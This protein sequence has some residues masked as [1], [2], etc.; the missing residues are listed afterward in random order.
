[1]NE[2]PIPIPER[3]RQAKEEI[4]KTVI[5]PGQ[6]WFLTL[7]FLLIILSVPGLQI[8]RD[9]MATGEPIR[10]GQVFEILPEVAASLSKAP[11]VGLFAANRLLLRDIDR[12][13]HALDDASVLKR[14]LLKPAQALLTEYLRTGSE[15]VYTGVNGW[16]FYRQA[17]EHLFGAPFLDPRRMEARRR[18]ANVWERPPQPDPRIALAEF[19]G[20]LSRRGI[21]LVLVAVPGKAAIQPEQFVGRPIPLGDDAAI[22]NP[23]T[24]DVF[25]F[26]AEQGAL[27]FDAAQSL[28]EYVRQA[29]RPAFLKTD[30]H[31]T[32]DAMERVARDL[33]A[34]VK[35]RID[36]PESRGSSGTLQAATCKAHGDL[37]RMLGLPDDQ[38]M[39][40]PESVTI[41]RVRQP[42]GSD[43]TPDSLSP[44]LLL[45]DSFGNIYSDPMLGWGAS[46]GLAEHLSAQL[47]FP[48][49]RICRNDDGA[50]ATRAELASELRLGNDR[51]R[52][53]RL[54]IWEFAE[55]EFSF[56]DWRSIPLTTGS[57][58]DGQ[59]SPVA[60]LTVLA[61]LSGMG[62]CP[63]PGSTPYR[64][65]L[66]WLSLTDF[67]E[68]AGLTPPVLA[69]IRT[70]EDGK[71]TT[72]ATLRTG[73]KYRFLLQ[74]WTDVKGNLGR[75][76]REDP[77]ADELVFLTPMF[78]RLADD[79]TSSA[80]AVLQYRDL[81]AQLAG[82]G[83]EMTVRGIDGWLFHRTELEQA[84]GGPFWGEAALK[85]GAA[86]R[87]PEQADPLSA[88][89]AYAQA[90]RE[91]GIHLLVV[92]VPGK[93]A[94]YPDKLANGQGDPGETRRDEVHKAFCD[95]LA[96]KGVPVID[97]VPEFL[98]ERR[99]AGD[100]LFC[101][102]DT[103][104]SPRGIQIM[105]RAIA[106]RIRK[107]G[108]LKDRPV[109]AYKMEDQVVTFR[110]DLR[111]NVDFDA[112]PD[113]TLTASIVGDPDS[114]GPVQADPDS[115]V[116]LLSD[117][118]GLIYSSGGDM[119]ATGAGLPE[120]LAAELG[121]PVEVIAVR[122]SAARP[123]RIN[124][125]RKIASTPGYIEKKKVIVW[126]FTV[127]ELTASSWGEI[128]LRR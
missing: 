107:E 36:L 118:H 34:F 81:C 120:H 100:P 49:D 3:E 96:S 67:P 102:Q 72:A 79:T 91:Q 13:E 2:P 40:L 71:A 97:L 29:D 73:Q 111:V 128:P 92:P 19:I 87:K 98:L 70:L 62:T 46:A 28:R 57:S 21:T 88:I 80:N 74:P 116:L 11:S 94:V 53:K 86:D 117:S 33:A 37:V 17:V 20:Q 122:G 1:M 65:H 56:G 44:V 104:T 27:V 85:A 121:F 12:Y 38:R 31:W 114:G 52:G 6:K 106:Q 25:A 84:A 112:M 5:S 95:R 22:R 82:K 26:A 63:K 61:T 69:Y 15:K 23:S 76:Q 125:F 99:K 35:S 109:H 18:S 16:L 41:R 50:Y 39:Y 119:H 58:V 60:P 93:S 51:L 32:P 42:D 54:V 64:D 43:W 10:K 108:W 55:R 126:C 101:R 45:G 14:L 4:G 105:A 83:G 77:D 113:E 68:Q 103:H 24:K 8:L 123:A 47:G 110:G 9:R 78:A 66:T 59:A 7:G 48:I 89:I 90:C 75:I 127:R 124:L 115:P 30:T